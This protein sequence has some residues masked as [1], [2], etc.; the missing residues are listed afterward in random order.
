MGA[1]PVG[2]SSAR[3]AIGAAVVIIAA[4]SVLHAQTPPERSNQRFHTGVEIIRLDLSAIGEDGRAVPDLTPAEFEVRI[5]GTPRTVRFARPTGATTGRTASAAPAAMFPGSF[6]TNARSAS[7]RALVFAIDLES[8]RAGTERRMLDTAAR[9]IEALGSNDAVSVAPIPG[10]FLDLTRDRA[11]AADALRALHGTN[12]SPMWR[13]EL[14]LEEA[15]AFDR[16]G[17]PNER[18]AIPGGDQTIIRRVIDRECDADE[19]RRRPA[20]EEHP[21]Q[22]ICPPEI[23][24]EARERLA[25]ERMHV[26]VVLSS[27]SSIADRLQHVDA[28][29]TIILLSGGLIFESEGLTWFRQAERALKQANVTLY[30]VHVDQAMADASVSRSVELQAYAARD[31]ESGLANVATM[32]GGAFFSGVGTAAGAFERVRTEISTGYELGVEAT[33][34]DSQQQS[35]RVEIAVKRPGVRLRYRRDVNFGT[36]TSATAKLAGLMTQPI[37]VPDLPIHAAAYTVRGEEAD[38]VRVLLVAELGRGIPLTEPVQYAIVVT[39]AGRTAFETNGTAARAGDIVR[40]QFATQLAP[41]AYRVRIAAADAS[42]RGGSLDIP[43][44]VG[45]RAAGG[46]HLSDLILGQIGSSFAPAIHAPA[47]QLLGSYLELYSAE[48]ARLAEAAVRFELRRAGEAAVLASANGRLRQ[49]DSDRRQIAEGSISGADLPPGDYTISAVVEAGGQPVGKVSRSIIVTS[50]AAVSVAVS[51]PDA[52][53]P[54]AIPAS[55]IKLAKG[56]D[57][58]LA[59]VIKKMVEYVAAYGEQAGLLVGVEKYTQY[60]DPYPP[61]HITAEFALV[62]TSNTTGWAG[63]RDVVEVNGEAVRDRRDRLLR[64]FTESSS[65]ISEAT[66]IAN[67]SARFN[68]GPVSRNFNV[69][70][71]TLFFFHPTNLGRFTFQRK[72]TKK[73]DDVETWEISFT[74]TGRPTMMGTRSGKDVPCQ[75]TVWVIPSN[76]TVVRTRLRLRNFADAFSMGESGAPRISPS[77]FQP[78]SPPPAPVGGGASAGSGAGSRGGATGVPAGGASGGGSAG[79]SGSGGGSGTSGGAGSGSGG[80]GSSG[81]RTAGENARP[82]PRFEELQMSTIQS[83]A[84][85]EVTFRHDPQLQL[86]LPS[87]MSEEYQGAIP[88]IIRRPIAGTARSIATYS[89]FKQFETSAKIVTPKE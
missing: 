16:A 49:T 84:E 63:F 23:Q 38:T 58:A 24:R 85:I 21:I 81:G 5:D 47:G 44:T 10:T 11:R 83:R 42:G 65:P 36:A 50:D 17:P 18:G 51:P 79:G 43:V 69:P 70:T 48:P 3:S 71:T 54:A 53:S 80:A 86:W 33:D 41:A 4:I 30:A 46:L 1:L 82:M 28:P 60:E 13:H 37:D 34:R 27:L 62:K 26:Q 67:E 74:E 76:G 19:G 6:A 87:R 78:T 89:D 52:P 12:S 64:L 29:R 57:P 25:Y 2:R 59:D 14:T 7:G 32:T 88:R 77:E 68:V 66:R 15:L 61:R 35:L 40:I 31:R 56:S 55:A 39:S 8:I 9:L 45:L 72:G 73:I 22:L 20:N 75:G